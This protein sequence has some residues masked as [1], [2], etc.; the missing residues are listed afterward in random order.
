LGVVAVKGE[1]K[2]DANGAAFEPFTL[3]LD[4]TRFTGRFRRAAGADPLA[5]LELAGDSLDIARYVPPP[6]PHSEPFTLP[7]AM[8]KALKF[9]GT[10]QL[11]EAK[12]Q[13]TLMKGVTLKL[14]LDEQGLRQP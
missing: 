1:W 12:Y 6:D 14:L 8:L 11:A 13:D 7:T 2:F 5:S 10:I 3:R 4:D 9:H